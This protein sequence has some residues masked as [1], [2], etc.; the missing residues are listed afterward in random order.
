MR[1]HFI[2]GLL[3]FRAY[4]QVNPR[5]PAKFTKTREIPRNSLKSVPNTCRYNIFEDLS[6]LLELFTCRKLANFW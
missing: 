5:N 1:G 6:W 3:V 2:T 4:F